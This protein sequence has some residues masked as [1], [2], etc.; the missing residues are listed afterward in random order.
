MSGDPLSIENLGFNKAEIVVLTSITYHGILSEAS[1]ST[2]FSRVRKYFRSETDNLDQQRIYRTRK[3]EWAEK[4]KSVT[5]KLL[6]IEELIETSALPEA[7]RDF[8]L[9]DTK[10]NVMIVEI[11]TFEPYFGLANEKE[12]DDL[13]YDENDKNA[14]FHFCSCFIGSIYSIDNYKT[15]CAAFNDCARKITKSI[16]GPNWTWAWIG[17]G[18]AVLLLTAPYLA[19]VIGGTMGLSGAAATSAGLAF[20]GGGSIATGGLGMSGG[21]FAFMAGG[22]ILGYSAGSS[23]YK[24]SLRASSKEELL[25]SCSK[26]YAVVQLTAGLNAKVEIC[27]KALAMQADYEFEAD[28]SFLSSS[29]PEGLKNDAKALVLRSFRRVMRGDL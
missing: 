16:S 29:R 11:S 15:A 2:S 6:E 12:W 3:K 25:I 18:S 14:Y 28:K 13:R 24:S 7:I 26:L 8:D 10:K 20:L 23:N 4:W 19:G 9:S 22:A 27:K 17:L 21:Y 1:T 5:C